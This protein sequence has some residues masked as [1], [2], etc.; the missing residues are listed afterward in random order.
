[1]LLGDERAEIVRY[2]LRMCEDDLT[3]GTSGNLSIRRG[4]L[5]AI[6]PGGVDYRTL[7]P[8]AI[9]VIDLDGNL[10]DGYLEPSSEVPMHTSVYRE[11]DTGAVVHTHPM[12]ATALSTLVDELPPIHYLIALLGGPVRTAP[13]A[14]YGSLEL[15]RNSVRG[16][17]GRSAVLLQN[18]GATTI[19]EDLSRAYTRSLYLEWM[20]R[21]YHH[22]CLLG[23][24]NILPEAEIALVAEKLA[25][26][27]QSVS[28][29]R[30]QAG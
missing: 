20:C 28:D 13:Y 7:D 19:G 22:A 1:M 5:I 6:T 27:G 25:S 11:L 4:D 29:R 2:C 15:A 21:V 14:T 18:H 24:P 17:E 16:L 8:E 30:P 9:C 23:R 10:V 12:F 3:V 26:Y